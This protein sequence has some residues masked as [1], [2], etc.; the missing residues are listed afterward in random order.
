M[1]CIPCDK[2]PELIFTFEDVA[3]KID[4][5]YTVSY[6]SMGDSW[7]SFHDYLPKGIWSTRDDSVYSLFGKLL[8]K[9]NQNNVGVY[10]NGVKH[11]SYVTPVFTSEYMLKEGLISMQLVN[12][13]WNTNATK[14][15]NGC[16]DYEDNELQ[17]VTFTAVSVH[18][19]YQST[20]EIPLVPYD[21]T[22]SAM[23]NFD[24]ANV[25]KVTNRWH[26]NKFRDMIIDNSV[27]TFIEFLDDCI[28]KVGNTTTQDYLRRFN[29]DYI[30]VKLTFDNVMQVDLK[31]QSV[32]ITNKPILR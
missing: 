14:I 15:M 23:D 16:N 7:I 17:K 3:C 13:N 1:I 4:Q 27:E 11:P 21:I 28:V 10:Y 19:S 29:D 18:T 6:T 12:I 26:F 20:A 22:K 8:Y 25:R 24:V 2:E 30:I 5:N 31:I 9:H 32:D